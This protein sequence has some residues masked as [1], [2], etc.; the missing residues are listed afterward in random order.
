M[1]NKKYPKLTKVR[2]AERSFDK[3]VGHQFP[4]HLN[5]D[6]DGA[7]GKYI[8]SLIKSELRVID[9]GNGNPDLSDYDIELKSKKDSSN[10]NW[11]IAS[12]TAADIIN[13]DYINS[14]VYRKLQALL[15][16]SHDTTKVTDVDL[17]YLDNDDAQER[18]ADYYENVRQQLTQYVNQ[19][20]SNF[21]D[22]QQFKEFLGVL[23]YSNNGT[24]FKF[25]IRPN[26]LENMLN[27]SANVSIRDQFFEFT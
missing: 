16:I 13:T 7:Y 23:E 26:R 25:R 1:A 8:D 11:T 24:N 20:G 10:T 3:L 6:D 4:E 21:S 27:M 18:I 15:T 9:P 2:V 19:N 14:A 17:T 12:M 22:S 5:K